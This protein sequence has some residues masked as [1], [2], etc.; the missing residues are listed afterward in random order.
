M[1]PDLTAEV[2][3]TKKRIAG[4]MRTSACTSWIA[5][6]AMRRF[7]H[8]ITCI[9][10][11]ACSHIYGTLKALLTQLKP[12]NHHYMAIHE[13]RHAEPSMAGMANILTRIIDN[14][15]RGEGHGTRFGGH[16]W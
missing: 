6:D 11:Y 7:R 10:I 12:H 5:M 1:T 14:L 2:I 13:G 8:R 3:D 15:T 4:L 9:I 16:V